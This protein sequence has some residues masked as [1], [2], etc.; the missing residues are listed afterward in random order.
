ML[1][2]LL[3]YVTV[4]VIGLFLGV[5]TARRAS[6]GDSKSTGS[7]DSEDRSQTN[8]HNLQTLLIRTTNEMRT[9]LN[10]IVGLSS[11][12]ED[13]KLNLQQQENVKMIRLAG[14]NLLGLIKDIQYYS[15]IETR[16]EVSEIAHF[17]PAQAI[18]D[19]LEDLANVLSSKPIEVTF[20]IDSKI[21]K[22]VAADNQHIRLVLGSIISNAAKF[23]RSGEIQIFV[24][25]VTGKDTPLLS[26]E[27]KDTGIGISEEHLKR[28]F[29]PV[30]PNAFPQEDFLFGGFSLYISHKICELMG[31]TMTVSSKEYEGSTFNFT[32]PYFALEAYP[33]AQKPASTAPFTVYPNITIATLNANLGKSL[34]QFFER[35]DITCR[36]ID[37]G[38][39]LT[40]ALENAPAENSVLLFDTAWIERPSDK[41]HQWIEKLKQ[42]ETPTIILGSEAS[43]GQF[44]K[45]P[46]FYQIPQIHRPIRPS[47]IVESLKQARKPSQ[48]DRN[49]ETPFSPDE[50]AGTPITTERKGS[51]KILVAED[52]KV[53]QKVISMMI[54]RLGHQSDLAED[55]SEALEMVGQE[56][57]DLIFMDLN[58]PNMSGLESTKA[59]FEKYPHA[60]ERPIII[61]ITAA[62][63]PANQ[64]ACREVGMKGF[65]SKPVKLEVLKKAI[66]SVKP[67]VSQL[68]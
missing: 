61:A 13:S 53:N 60:Q 24:K 14:D 63:T 12:L 28:I 18:E 54:K 31:G 35:L 30:D 64:Q 47:R 27:I 40:E 52:D 25:P 59:I 45:D 67:R 62:V 32:A 57:Y 65:I 36:L 33:A 17:N 1:S 38:I 3:S 19:T 6:I 42:C 11:V 37:D 66:S 58:M 55:G 68:A 56:D 41:K 44:A 43:H 7:Q 5:F 21:P 39:A 4:A 49:S 50:N 23:T 15:R 22:A 51:L 26:F 16:S 10:S 46:V 8:E 9:P 2:T 29:S 48:I 34:I 20:F